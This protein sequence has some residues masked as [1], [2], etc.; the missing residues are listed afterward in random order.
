MTYCGG[1]VMT[2]TTEAYIILNGDW[3]SQSAAQ[4]ILPS[5][6]SALTGSDCLNIAL[7]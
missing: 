4:T 5:F 2:G 1:P 3:S 6:F 7:A